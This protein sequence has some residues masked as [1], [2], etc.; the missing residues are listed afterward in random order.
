MYNNN[1]LV[2]F[3]SASS[4]AVYFRTFFFIYRKHEKMFII[5]S[6]CI[7]PDTTIK[8]NTLSHT[9]IEKMPMIVRDEKYLLP[10]SEGG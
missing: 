2:S 4:A 8:D 3:K 5:L 7:R 1:R 6:L 9:N 10:K